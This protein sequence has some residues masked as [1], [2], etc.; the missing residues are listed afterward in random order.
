MAGGEVSGGAVRK[1]L[2]GPWAMPGF[3]IEYCP[4]V[5][6]MQEYFDSYWDSFSL[7]YLQGVFPQ[8]QNLNYIPLTSNNRHG[9]PHSSS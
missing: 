3:E 6:Q 7:S 8:N 1:A 4:A 9:F 5:L 2:P